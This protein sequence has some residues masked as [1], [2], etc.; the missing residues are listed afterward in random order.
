MKELILN[1][2]IE[3]EILDKKEEIE[4]PIEVNK[5][6]LEDDISIAS[7]I[8]EYMENYMQDNYCSCSF[9]ESQNHCDC[10]CGDWG[11]DY[12]IINIES[13]VGKEL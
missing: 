5:D 12:E 4:I 7:F 1:V 10:G 3:T 8:I 9:N 13:E 11:Y 6:L 2:T